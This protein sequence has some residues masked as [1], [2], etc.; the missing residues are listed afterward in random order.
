M[1]NVS[2]DVL[3]IDQFTV[4]MKSYIFKQKIIKNLYRIS[5][6]EFPAN[7]DPKTK[8]INTRA[9]GHLLH[10]AAAVLGQ[11][12]VGVVDVGHI[13]G[14]P[15]ALPHSTGARPAARRQQLVTCVLLTQSG[16]F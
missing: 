4:R 7:S 9:L 15:Q 13:F 1:Y 16:S 10:H 3:S 6:C 2:V 5:K 11:A 8:Y 14:A 12:A